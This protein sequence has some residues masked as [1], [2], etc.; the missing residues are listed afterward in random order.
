MEPAFVKEDNTLLENYL[1][2]IKNLSR[3]YK[4]KLVD[5]LNHD[6]EKSTSSSNDWID[7]LYGSFT[8]NISVE[9]LITEIR[10]SRRFFREK[11]D[12]E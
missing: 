6:I 3:E 9:D 4:I 7:R 8:S 1:G 10:T 11:P 12:F 2:L 5:S